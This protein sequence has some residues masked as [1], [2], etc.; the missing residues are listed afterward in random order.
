MGQN[1]SGEVTHKLAKSW[2]FSLW[3]KIVHV[4]PVLKSCFSQLNWFHNWKYGN[5]F[6]FNSG[7]NGSV[8]IV[9][10]TATGPQWGEFAISGAEKVFALVSSSCFLAVDL[11]LSSGQ[12][13]LTVPMLRERHDCFSSE[14]ALFQYTGLKVIFNVQQDEY[15]PELTEKAGVRVLVHDQERTAFLEEDGIDIPVGFSTAIGIR[16]V[17]F[18]Y[19]LFPP[20]EKKTITGLLDSNESRPKL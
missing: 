14:Q 17:R 16:M 19:A 6:T 18:V 8:P 10:S 4:H 20:E 15:I 7:R 2:G 3:H 12:C 11:S 5:C 1:R 9:Q 13:R